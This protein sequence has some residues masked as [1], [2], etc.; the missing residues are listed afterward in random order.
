MFLLRSLFREILLNFVLDSGRSERLKPFSI[1]LKTRIM[2]IGLE[3]KWEELLRPEF[4]KPYFQ[5]LSA[6]VDSQYSSCNCFPPAD[7]IFEAFRLCPFE[8]VKVVLLGQDPYH[9]P[10]QAM[11][12]SFSVPEGVKLPPSLRNIYKEVE[13]D[14][15]A[16]PVQNGDLTR[17]ARQGVL[18]LNATLTVEQGKAGSHAKKGWEVFTDQVIKAVSDHLEGVVFLLWGSY[19]GR[20]RELIDESRHLVLES[21]HPSPLSAYRGF[22]GNLHFRRANEYLEAHGKKTIAW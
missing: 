1:H 15:G 6:F 19:A 9:E 14:C 21:A 18:L 13:A 7:R 11:G 8:D 4:A 17:W 12:L 5:S 3:K 20:K 22:F 10:G 2:L 16:K